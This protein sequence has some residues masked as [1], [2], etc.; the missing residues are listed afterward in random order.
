M[1][2]QT[3]TDHELAEDVAKF[4]RKELDERG[5][6]EIGIVV[7]VDNAQYRMDGRNMTEDDPADWPALAQTAGQ[8]TEDKFK[9][10]F[11]HR[12]YTI[13]TDSSVLR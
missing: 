9:K 7:L 5:L 1:R 8:L 12:H 10:A 2:R 11:G 3:V 13:E 4:F 6:S